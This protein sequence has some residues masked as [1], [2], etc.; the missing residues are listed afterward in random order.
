MVVGMGDR[1]RIGRQRRGAVQ[2]GDRRQGD[3]GQGRQGGQAEAGDRRADAD[4][5]DHQPPVAPVGQPAQRPE[6]HCAADHRGA[7]EAGDIRLAQAQFL[8]IERR[9]RPEGAVGQAGAE[10]R[11]GGHR[12]VLDQPPQLQGGA[13]RDLRRGRA[14]QRHRD[15]GDGDEDRHQDEQLRPGRVAQPQHL[16]ADHRDQQVQ[17]GIGRQDEAAI[18]IVRA[19]VQPTLDHH[20]DAG[21]AEAGHDAQDDPDL[22][23]QDNALQQR[24]DRGQRGEGGEGADMADPGDHDR[25][26]EAAQGQAAEIGGAQEADQDVA[27]AQPVRGDRREDRQQAVAG[28]D[29]RDA[30]EQR[31]NRGEALRHGP[32]R[33]RFRL[34]PPWRPRGIADL[35]SWSGRFVTRGTSFG[36]GRQAH[37]PAWLRCAP[38]PVDLPGGS[39]G[40]L[41]SA[42][43]ICGKATGGG[44]YTVQDPG[45]G[46]AAMATGRGEDGD[47]YRRADGDQEPRI[48]GRPGADQR[49]GAGASRPPG[50][51]AGRRG[52]RHRSDQAHSLH[53][54][55]GFNAGFF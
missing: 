42:A 45:A 51:R 18:G 49:A 7:D 1:Q 21:I 39:R 32:Y 44:P 38:P 20:R 40:R 19:L 31:G 30:D 15:G 24:G 9:Q 11:A 48:P 47:A 22:A 4:A 53:E 14:G 50:Q 27:E 29:Q 17:P 8:G 28:Q 36:G 25:H 26:Q 43:V 33:W 13:G 12:A 54:G 10:H 52:R 46:T 34:S 37:A 6:R 16:L 2:E 55:R 5:G 35:I 41:L 3:E 23:R